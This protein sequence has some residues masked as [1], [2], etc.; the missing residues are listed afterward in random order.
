MLKIRLMMIH[1]TRN[2]RLQSGGGAVEGGGE[3][4]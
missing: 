1:F 3:V 2:D 4:G